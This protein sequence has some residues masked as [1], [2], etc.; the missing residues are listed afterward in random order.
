MT[1]LLAVCISLSLGIVACEGSK[2]EP[3]ESLRTTLDVDIRESA[4]VRIERH[5]DEL[6]VSI[7]L[8]QGFGV[9]PPGERL[10]GKG[11]LERFPEAEVSLYTARFS[12]R[13]QPDGPCGA[14]P[15]SLAL[16]LHRRDTGPRLSGSLTAYCGESVWH[17][18]PARSPLRLSSPPAEE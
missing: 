11:R 1:R 14:E 17:G 18:L 10:R 16:S 2:D 4:S 8:S 5:G 6:D 7:E 13:A 12:V 3:D 15:I 9:A